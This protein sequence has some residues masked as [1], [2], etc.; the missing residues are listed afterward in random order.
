MLMRTY[1]VEPF[2]ARGTT[3]GP[4]VDRKFSYPISGFN[5]KWIIYQLL[6]ERKIPANTGSMTSLNNS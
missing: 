6:S 4:S 3:M 5:E 2:I 1:L